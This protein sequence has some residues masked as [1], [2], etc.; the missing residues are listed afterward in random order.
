MSGFGSTGNIP[1]S[2]AGYNDTPSHSDVTM[3]D[4]R[5]PP[6]SV[7]MSDGLDGQQAEEAGQ[8]N[9]RRTKR[10]VERNPDEVPR[11]KDETGAGVQ[12]HL[13]KFIEGYAIQSIINQFCLLDFLETDMMVTSSDSKSDLRMI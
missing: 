13:I 9:A 8:R 10:R 7:G 6:P 2:Q 1:S 12:E 3:Q 11:V 4:H 5:A